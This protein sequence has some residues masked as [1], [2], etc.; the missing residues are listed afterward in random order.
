AARV[1]RRRH[2]QHGALPPR[3]RQQT[4]AAD[5]SRPRVIGWQVESQSPGWLAAK[6][7]EAAGVIQ[8]ASFIQRTIL[9]QY[10]SSVRFPINRPRWLLGA[11]SWRIHSGGVPVSRSTASNWSG[12]T[13]SSALPARRYIGSRRR[14]RSIFCPSAIKLPLASS[15]RRYSFSI[16]SR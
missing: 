1:G 14:E 12:A 2:L 5:L 15:L 3:L 10:S 8:S 7:A 4:R 16:T 13:T 6:V 9:G 11:T